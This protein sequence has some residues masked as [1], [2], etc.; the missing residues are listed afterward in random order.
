MR[1]S[2][3]SYLLLLFVFALSSTAQAQLLTDGQARESANR[4]AEKIESITEIIRDLTEQNRQMRKQL[5]SISQQRQQLKQQV[6]ELT[7][8]IE[9]IQQSSKKQKADI[10]KYLDN[11]KILTKLTL[12][13]EKVS[14][15]EKFI[16]LPPEQ[17]MYNS[18]FELLKKEQHKEAIASFKQLLELYPQGQLSPNAHY[19]ISKSQ[20]TLGEFKNA[21]AEAETLITEYPENG[22]FAETMLI[23][24]E[25][26]RGLG[27]E[28]EARAQL[29]LLLEQFPTSIAADEA[30]QLLAQ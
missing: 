12:L 19:W 3:S 9:E 27:M 2:S 8:K 21:K 1:W 17:D 25:A 4:N 6:R 16:T 13:S 20:L 7:G 29:S 23:I 22:R 15:L 30:R 18:A 26:M 11:P 14:N 24:A 5:T 28:T 10:Q